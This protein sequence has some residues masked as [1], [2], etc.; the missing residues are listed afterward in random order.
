MRSAIHENSKDIE[1]TYGMPREL[2]KS[3]LRIDGTTGDPA[4]GGAHS[5]PTVF[6]AGAFFAPD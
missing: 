3:R 5:K 4:K 2:L 6:K 1:P